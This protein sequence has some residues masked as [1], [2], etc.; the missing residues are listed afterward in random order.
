MPTSDSLVIA[1]RSNRPTVSDAVGQL[2]NTLRGR[3]M[4]QHQEEDA[5]A[6]LQ[7][8]QFLQLPP[9]QQQANFARLN[10]A[11]QKFILNTAGWTP[12]I[13][14]PEEEFS[15]EKAKFG[16]GG[17]RDP[18]LFGAG[19]GAS[20]RYQV[21]T[22]AT[23]PS[24]VVKA[25]VANDV[26][27]KPAMFDPKMQERQ[28]IEDK[29]TLTAEEAEKKSQADRAFNVIT[30]PT[31]DQVTMP[32]SKSKITLQGA[33][34]DE[35]RSLAGKNRAETGKIGEETKALRSSGTLFGGGPGLPGTGD[36]LVKMAAARQLDP[37]LLK[38]WKPEQLDAFVQKVRQIDPNFST[39]DYGVQVAAKKS[40]T[41]GPLADGKRAANRAI[42]HVYSLS[43]SLDALNNNRFPAVNAAT[44]W[45][46]RQGGSK[47]V[48][49]AMRR[50]ELDAD[51]VATEISKFFKGGV[52][53]EGEIKEWRSKI[54][55]STTPAEKDAVIQEAMRLL[56]SGL[57]AFDDQYQQA[58]GIP[59][60]F[61]VLSPKAEMLLKRLKLDP[62][63][64]EGVSGESSS[65]PGGDII[66]TP[67]GLKWKKNSDGSMTQVP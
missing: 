29:R 37:N 33:Q 5:I 38:R 36:E 26:Y 4:A 52:P 63:N 24:D 62:A 50:V 32:E 19:G 23:A 64:L 45:V 55:T 28:A 10:P 39:Q 15:T 46:M 58:V 14:S 12:H 25:N 8:Q 56:G 61:K 9:D 2:V 44:N 65:A 22:G 67:D 30:K 35:Q 6:K 31:F 21:A 7:A 18:S 20:A 34:S 40:F 17:F 47:D 57:A 54:S 1:P 11:A 41:S 16:L 48:Q 27:S 53:A 3:Q 13:P 43:R 60:D 51:A 42:G 59:R 66:K 49:G